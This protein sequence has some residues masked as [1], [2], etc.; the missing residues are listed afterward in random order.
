MK[1]YQ[2]IFIALVV[3]GLITMVAQM[4]RPKAQVPVN[5]SL[6]KKI[7]SQ[8]LQFEAELSSDD[9][10]AISDTATFYQ[11][12]FGD[13]SVTLSRNA[14]NQLGV[15]EYLT[16][17]D[18]RKKTLEVIDTKPIITVAGEWVLRSES[19]PDASS[20]VAYL[21]T[22]NWVYSISTSS[23]SLYDE[24]EE[25]AKSFRYTGD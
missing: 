24:V 18:D 3:V 16:E 12:T 2:K 9:V 25:I 8:N 1:K 6:L 22:N 19:Y 21:W 23:P 11:L 20:K 5:E 10:Y 17:S 14:T 13:K 7:S 15:R 4:F